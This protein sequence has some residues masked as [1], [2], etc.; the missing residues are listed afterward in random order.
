M[1]LS[2]INWTLGRVDNLGLSVIFETVILQ[3][4]TLYLWHYSDGFSKTE[5]VQL[6]DVLSGYEYGAR[7]RL[8]ETV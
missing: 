5:N 3:D 1:T 7:L 6:L 4:Y 2:L 8:E